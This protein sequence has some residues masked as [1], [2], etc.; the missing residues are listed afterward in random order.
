MFNQDYRFVCVL[1]HS[2]LTTEERALKES[3]KGTLKQ[4]LK[5]SFGEDKKSQQLGIEFDNDRV[6]NWNFAGISRAEKL[7]D[8]S[9]SAKVYSGSFDFQEFFSRSVDSSKGNFY[10]KRVALS[11]PNQVLVVE[12]PFQAL[13][14]YLSDP[15]KMWANQSFIAEESGEAENGFEETTINFSKSDESNVEEGGSKKTDSIL[16]LQSDASDT[17]YNGDSDR[18]IFGEQRSSINTGGDT[19]RGSLYDKPK[20]LIYSLLSDDK[21]VE[22]EEKE[23]TFFEFLHEKDITDIYF[24]IGALFNTSRKPATK[25]DD[26]S[27]DGRWSKAREK[28]TNI[29]KDVSSEKSVSVSHFDKDELDLKVEVEDST[30]KYSPI[31]VRILHEYGDQFVTG[32][33]HGCPVRDLPEGAKQYQ[34]KNVMG[35]TDADDMWLNFSIAKREFEL[36]RVDGNHDNNATRMVEMILSD[37]S[38][39]QK[40][41]EL[42]DAVV[43][44]EGS[45]ISEKFNELSKLASRAYMKSYEDKISEMFPGDPSEY[46]RDL[47]FHVLQFDILVYPI[48][49]KTLPEYRGVNNKIGLASAREVFEQ[50]IFADESEYSTVNRVDLYTYIRK[51][52]VYKNGGN[53]P[54]NDNDEIVWREAPSLDELRDHFD[55]H[56]SQLRPWDLGHEESGPV[57]N[58]EKKYA[59]DPLAAISTDDFLYFPE[60][61]ISTS[62]RNFDDFDDFDTSNRPSGQRLGHFDTV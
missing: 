54:E 8:T 18:L 49:L 40:Y 13:A 46:A 9:Y 32:L 45:E 42:R 16:Y 52:T 30:G 7:R 12:C 36:L 43:S 31:S 21:I 58:K 51:N 56:H 2:E 19:G 27:G 44:S 35:K 59:V 14:D 20:I 11:D 38:L 4:Y 61:D 53:S 48:H 6:T 50:Y 22:F 41:I 39:R 23:M 25:Q 37:D 55:E 57:I 33:Y 62:Y 5:A 26:K 29:Y 10:E 24:Y 17:I 15:H 47:A 3:I 1:P 34:L 60:G 28:T